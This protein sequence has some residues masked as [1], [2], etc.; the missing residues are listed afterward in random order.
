MSRSR[1]PTTPTRPDDT[2]VT[3]TGTFAIPAHAGLRLTVDG[4][5]GAGIPLVDATAKLSVY[6]E[7]GVAGEASAGVQVDWT[8]R[9]GV[10]LDARGDIFVEPKF[11]FGVDASVEVT[12]G[13]WRLTTT[14]YEHT[15]H[16]ADF[17]YGSSLRFGLSLPI[18]YE[19]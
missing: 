4:G 16:L 14:L 3:G 13:V 2:T 9:T 5:V 12:V 6:G 1:S 7:V 15:W 10:V 11:K 8:P 18:H 19:S 17:E